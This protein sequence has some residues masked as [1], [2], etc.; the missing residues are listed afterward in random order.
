MFCRKKPSTT[1]CVLRGMGI[2]LSVV[3]AMTVATYFLSKYNLLGHSMKQVAESCEDAMRH[4]CH[5]AKK[6][7]LDAVEHSGACDCMPQDD[8]PS[9]LTDLGS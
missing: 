7:C 8:G 4:A 6:T 1:A 2:A 9:R 5:T 3:G